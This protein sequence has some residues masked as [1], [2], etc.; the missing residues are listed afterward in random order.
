MGLFDLFKGRS[1]RETVQED[2]EEQT[3][4]EIYSHMR[5][6]V[7]TPDGQLLFVAKLVNVRDRTA[8]LQQYSDSSLSQESEES[9]E[10]IPVHIR[11]YNDHERKAVYLEGLI[12]PKPKH[13]WQVDQLVLVKVE[14]ARAFFRLDTNIDATATTFGGQNTGERPCKLLN[15][16]VGGA[17]IAS[18]YQYRERDKFLL[19]VKLFED[20]E[21]SAMF[22]QVL[23][24][25]VRGENK[26]E[27]GCQ[28]LE[29][30]ENDQEKITQ[31][32]FAAQRK[33]R[34]LSR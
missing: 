12:T 22:C 25:I 17:C 29:L 31:N 13:I 10:P 21:V 33:M 7:T 11:G 1:K 30:N 26:Y 23:R 6:E 28:F 15:I 19:T 24:I 14:N 2:G 3:G 34:S 27:Y 8:E 9:E 5:V 16:S 20:R 4:L 18:E 32:I